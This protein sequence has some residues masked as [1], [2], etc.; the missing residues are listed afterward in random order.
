MKRYNV[1]V[2]FYRSYMMNEIDYPSIK[3]YIA[4]RKKQYSKSTRND[5]GTLK[6]I[7]NST[8]NR[9]VSFISSV[10]RE[11]LK[12][13]IIEKYPFAGIILKLEEGQKDINPIESYGK[14]NKFINAFPKQMQKMITFASL[15]GF[16]IKTV[17]NLRKDSFN[18][19]KKEIIILKQFAKNKKTQIFPLSDEAFNILDSIKNESEYF[20][21]NSKTGKPYR[22]IR[23]SFAKAVKETGL[24]PKTT[25]HDLRRTFGNNLLRM[26]YPLKMISRAMGHSGISVTERYL[27][28]N[29][30]QDLKPMMKEYGRKVAEKSKKVATNVA[31]LSEYRKAN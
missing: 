30:E 8:V 31:T 24:N 4:W 26:G 13:G 19:D 14:L 5:D 16:R 29:E 21:L 12:D 20:F 28:V 6:H 10:L 17:F 2:K 15:S 7:S 23:G 11:A 18:R 27:R 3:Q 22:D 25:F 1:T 9:E